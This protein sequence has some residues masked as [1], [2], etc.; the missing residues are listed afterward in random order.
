MISSED[1]TALPLTAVISSPCRRPARSGG[2]SRMTAAISTPGPVW[3]YWPKPNAAACC[4]RQLD[5][6]ERRRTD[7]HGRRRAARLD[8]L[9]E[10][11][12]RLDRDRVG[13]RTTC[14]TR[15][16]N[17]VDAA[18]SIPT[19]RPEVSRSG[20][21]IARND[22][23]VRLDQARQLLG[24]AGLVARDDRPPERRHGSRDAR[25]RAGAARVPERG[26][27]LADGHRV[28]GRDRLEIRGALELD[29][30]DVL[31]PRVADDRRRVRT[32]R[33]RARR[34]GPT[35]RRR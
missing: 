22:G 9:R 14:E 10:V 20:P 33:S 5:T 7:V 8:L 31:R 13:R 21:P 18:V 16:E 35:S 17:P 12:R 34:R 6:E 24:V 28:A 32:T 25:Q 30:R 19:T 27:R 4:A 11:Q 2:P 15:N 26:H 3:P 29:D 1:E 23:C